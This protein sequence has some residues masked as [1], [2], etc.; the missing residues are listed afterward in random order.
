MTA[1]RV[2]GSWLTLFT[3]AWL[4]IWTIQLTP[5]Q[6]LLPLQLDTQNT[7][8]QWL[9]GVVWSGLVLSAGGVAGIVAAPLAGRLSD[10]TRSRW[11][12]RRPWAESRR[13]PA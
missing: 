2:G 11:G 7:G 5:V 1:R 10:R 12:R 9:D 3:L 4:A 6:L 13:S 8:G